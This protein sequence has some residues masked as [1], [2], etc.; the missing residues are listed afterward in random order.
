MASRGSSFGVI[1]LSTRSSRRGSSQCARQWLEDVLTETLEVVSCERA[2]VDKQEPDVLRK[3]HNAMWRRSL[4]PL[5]DDDG[6]HEANDGRPIRVVLT[7]RDGLIHV[8]PA[9]SKRPIDKK[10]GR[11]DRAGPETAFSCCYG[12]SYEPVPYQCAVVYFRSQRQNRYFA[13]TES[14]VSIMLG[15]TVAQTI[16]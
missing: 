4:L 11:R 16:S 7:V 10:R 6:M 9:D 13:P 15:D 14:T 3:S 1:G 2:H 8:A 5:A 12:A